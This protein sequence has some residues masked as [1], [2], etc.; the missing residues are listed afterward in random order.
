MSKALHVLTARSCAGKDHLASTLVESGDWELVVSATTRPP[1]AGE[2]DGVH[3]H[4]LTREEFEERIRREEL[5]EHAEFS[6]NYY[7]TPASEVDRIHARGKN[8]LAIVEPNGAR[9]LLYGALQTKT[10]LVLM[11]IHASQD[12]ITARWIQRF[13]NDVKECEKTKKPFSDDLVDYYAD[14][15]VASFFE[16]TYWEKSF[17]WDYVFEATKTQ[18]ECDELAS[19]ITQSANIVK[20]SVPTFVPSDRSINAGKSLTS[21]SQAKAFREKVKKGMQVYIQS[22]FVE[23][24]RSDF[25]KEVVRGQL[26]HVNPVAM[27]TEGMTP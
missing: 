25:Q 21:T 4:F 20:P 19:W 6:G 3:Y 13:F 17:N 10:P 18:E 12:L 8:P 15:F 24:A 16:E 7:G 9:S 23:S 5:L 26:A 14:R 1:R 27:K 11:T 22:P 2:I